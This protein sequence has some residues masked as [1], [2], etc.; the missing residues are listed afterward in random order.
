MFLELSG[1]NVVEVEQPLLDSG[2]DGRCVGRRTVEDDQA[3]GAVVEGGDQGVQDVSTEMAG[4][5]DEGDFE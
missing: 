1:I 3:D 2:R 5:A 4:V